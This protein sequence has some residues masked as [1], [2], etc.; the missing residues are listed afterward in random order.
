[1]SFIPRIEK[2]PLDPSRLRR[3]PSSFS[4]IDRRFVRD[5]WIE[6]LSR[7][8]ILVYL[9]LVTV[10]DRDGLSYY[11]DPRLSGTLKIP[12][13]DLGRARERLVDLGLLVYR[14]PLYQVLDLARERI[15]RRSGRTES[16]A[17][18]LKHMMGG[19]ETPGLDSASGG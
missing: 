10:A 11:S 6:R 13:E 15:D 17:S 19:G 14:S 2:R 12:L 8:E 3:I 5:G 7:D 16:L 18:I 4:W 9:F 1:M